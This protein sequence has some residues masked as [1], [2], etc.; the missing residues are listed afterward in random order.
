MPVRLND[1]TRREGWQFG[2]REDW[3]FADLRAKLPRSWW[4]L[5]FFVT[6]V[7]QQVGGRLR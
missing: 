2:A 7:S 6:Y 1:D 3:R 5:S 4:L